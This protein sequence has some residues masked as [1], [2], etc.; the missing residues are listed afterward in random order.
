MLDEFKR[1]HAD[2]RGPLD[3]WLSE[4]EAAEWSG[5]DDVK[6]RYPSASLITGSRV[7]FNIKG[8]SFRLDTKI[9]YRT[10]I[11]TV[12]RVGTHAQYDKWKF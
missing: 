8:N 2:V 9:A 10:Q 4:A 11:V 6:A 3:S 5:P 12:I 7:M 1:H